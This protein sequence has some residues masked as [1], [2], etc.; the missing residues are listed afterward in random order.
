MCVCVS[1]PLLSYTLSANGGKATKVYKCASFG[2]GGKVMCS[3]IY[4]GGKGLKKPS[5][6]DP[7]PWPRSQ[8]YLHQGIQSLGQGT[9]K[10]FTKE[11]NALVKE[12]RRSSPRDAKRWPRSHEGLHQGIQSLGQGAMKAFTKGSKDLA[13]EPRFP[14]PRDPRP[15]PR[16]Q[17]GL[18]HGSQEGLDQG[19]KKVFTKGSKASVKGQEGLG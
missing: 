4:Y 2:K 19:A 6:R 9:K 10:A 11:F 7:R 3:E 16:S 15:F 5:P 13:K 1:C 8:E 17:E 18:H 14:S 12:P